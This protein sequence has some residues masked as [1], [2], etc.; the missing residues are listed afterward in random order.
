MKTKLPGP[1]LLVGIM[2]SM[3][4]CVWLS[5]LGPINLESLKGWQTLMAAFVALGAAFVAYAAV[6]LRLRFDREQANLAL[7]REKRRLLLKLQFSLEILSLEATTVLKDLSMDTRDLNKKL[8]IESIK[9]P[10]P[11]EIAEAWSHL[12]AFPVSTVQ[13]LKGIRI[14]LRQ[15]KEL[16][17]P[18]Q[19]IL[20]LDVYKP[21][22]AAARTKYLVEDI[23]GRCTATA[24]SLG[25]QIGD[26]TKQTGI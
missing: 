17:E 21:D 14:A 4:L 3:I 12:D 8:P 10:E 19:T 6:L 20:V 24:A 13:E 18:L 25:S 26:L 2:T 16:L 11:P 22:S 5:I 23:R 9:M 15:Y 1:C 7:G